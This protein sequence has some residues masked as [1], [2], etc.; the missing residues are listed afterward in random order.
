MVRC[1]RLHEMRQHDLNNGTC[2]V[3]LIEMDVDA[4]CMD[5]GHPGYSQ[6]FWRDV[7]LYGVREAFAMFQ[8]LV[9]RHFPSRRVRSALLELKRH[10]V[11]V[12]QTPVA[13]QP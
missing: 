8:Q 11:D 6:Q 12:E 5:A 9:G 2:H 10:V 3:R 4:I 13:R 7:R 1:L